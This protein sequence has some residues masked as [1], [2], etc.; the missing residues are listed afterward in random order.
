MRTGRSGEKFGGDHST[1]TDLG[2]RI[3]D[4]LVKIPEV[5]KVSPGHITGN[6]G[7]GRGRVHVKI[8]DDVGSVKLMCKQSGSIQEVRVFTAN[9]QN[10]KLTLAKWLR[11]N[12]ID[13]SFG[14]HANK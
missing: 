12:G 13:I 5:S 8:I 7:S 10:V 9:P 4:M 2:V 3:A 11:D 1:F 6:V 14:D